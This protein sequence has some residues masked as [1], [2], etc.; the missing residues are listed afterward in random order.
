VWSMI[1]S[2]STITIERPLVAIAKIPQY[3]ETVILED[4]AD[5]RKR[6]TCQ[7]A[8]GR[9]R[10]AVQFGGIAV[11]S[12]R[13][14]DQVERRRR[15]RASATSLRGTRLQSTLQSLAIDALNDFKTRCAKSS[16]EPIEAGSALP[17]ECGGRKRRH[18]MAIR[19]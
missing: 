2:A 12:A 10:G 16:T 7:S 8:D 6:E 4:I 15:P 9:V 18:K 3:W 13:P 17:S 1:H 11:N 19:G 5:L 14:V